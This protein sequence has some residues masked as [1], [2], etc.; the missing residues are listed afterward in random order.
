[1]NISDKLNQISLFKPLGNDEDKIAKL[2]QIISQK[3]YDAKKYIIKEGEI[4]EKMYILNKGTVLIEKKSAMGDSF[5]VVKLD[6]SMNPFFGELALLDED[7]RS[8]S[9]YTLT[10]VECFVIEKKVFEKFCHDHPEIGFLIIREIAKSLARKLR[11]TTYDNMY[12][13][14]ALCNEDSDLNPEDIE[15]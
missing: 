9:V 4:G 2:E 10:E 12:L 1:M 15:K 5:P 14:G 3:R 11:C 8:A 13:I 6:D 7:Q